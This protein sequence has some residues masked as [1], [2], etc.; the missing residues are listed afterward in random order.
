MH[1]PAASRLPLVD[2]LHGRSVPDPYRWLED[3]ASEQT[4]TWSQAQDELTRPFLDAL[5]G[6]R[7]L[8][9]ALGGLL[10]AGA[11]GAPV[12]RGERAFFTSRTGSQQHA[13]LVLREAGDRT[14]LDPA[15]LDPSGLTTLDAWSPSRDG[16]LLAYQLSS[17]GDEES[18][19]HVLDVDSGAEVEPPLDRTRY[20]SVAWLP[21]SSGFYYV[22]RLAADSPFDRRVY[23]HRLGSGSEADTDP[24]VHDEYVFGEGRDPRTYYGV[25]LSRDGRWL[26]VSASVGTEPRDDVWIADL[27][28]GPAAEGLRPVQEGVDARCAAAVAFDGRLYVWTDRD[29]PRGR[30]CAADPST[31]TDWQE[32]VPE[33]PDAVLTDFALTRDTVVVCR[34]RHAVAELAELERTTGHHRR[35]LTLPGPGTV[36]TLISRPDG[37]DEVWIGWTDW[38]TPPGVLVHDTTSAGVSPRV[39]AQAPGAPPTVQLT[40]RQE[41]YRSADG[42]K[43]RLSVLAPGEHVDEPDRPRP[44][45]LYGYGGFS[46]ALDPG[47]T[48]SALAWVAAGGVWAVAHLRGGAEEGESWHR[49]GMRAAKQNVFDD[50]HAA[51]EHLRSTGR[52]DRLG[53]YG[54]SNGGLLV[55]AALTQR[56]DLYDAV[57]CSAPLLDMVRYELFGLGRTWNDEF[58]TADD[59]AELDWLLGYSPYHA[60][61]KGG[62]DPATVHPATIYP[63]TLFEVFDADTRVDPLHARKMCAALQAVQPEDGPPILLRRETD[64]GHAA[65]SVDRTVALSVDTLS[66]L[67]AQL[68]LDPTQAD[69]LLGG[70]VLS[71]DV[72]SS[73]GTVA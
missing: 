20:S 38:T 67:A 35:D 40:A 29:A 12:Q 5:P 37:G 15:A 42:T 31:P 66:F 71:S 58:G 1:Y 46:I 32:L 6:R 8:A 70:D 55:G 68:G 17:G 47:Y 27:D 59:P 14:L 34:S 62:T 45:V 23:L 24:G 18:V 63:A 2:V 4:R 48:V 64:V 36:T 9:R 50:L 56:P 13:V 22:R 3:A 30:L 44:T 19:L 72:L 33:D 16:R 51:A 69:G 21:D 57:V 7:E 61:R 10:G 11:V 73:D 54:G 52:A 25:S 43:V 41:V 60:V 53:I 28:A 49:A 39:W 65:R 26:V